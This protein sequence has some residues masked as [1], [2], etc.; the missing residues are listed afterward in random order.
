MSQALRIMPT[1]LPAEDWA[2][3]F[4][5]QLSHKV[6]RG[7]A[8]SHYTSIGIGGPAT[9]F[10]RA[11]SRD[12]LAQMIL[13]ARRHDVEVLILDDGR[14]LLVGDWGFDLSLIHI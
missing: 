12:E 6:Q 3:S 13:M 1:L 7:V 14:R 9:L 10:G 8:L 5:R 4:Q 2:S 11:G